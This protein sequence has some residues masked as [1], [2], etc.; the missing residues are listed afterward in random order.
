MHTYL[1]CYPCFLRQALA[2]LRLITDQETEQ[3][4]V[5]DQVMQAL[6]TL[7]LAYSPPRIA[8]TVYE[9]VARE[10]GIEDP[11]QEIKTASNRQALAA[12]P[13]LV[14]IIAQKPNRLRAAASLAISGN[15]IDFGV[16]HEG[17]KVSEG[18]NSQIPD[19][20]DLDDF[21]AFEQQLPGTTK[22]LYI[23][24]N[25]GEIVADKIFISQ[26][27]AAYP[28]LKVGFAV[29]GT[30]IINDVTIVDAEQVGMAEVAGII[31]SGCRAPAL[32]EDEMSPEMADWFYHATMIIAKG[33]GNYEALSQSKQAIFFLLQCKCPVVADDLKVEV[34]S[35]I[36]KYH[37]RKQG[38]LK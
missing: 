4:R 23:G 22:L 30:P 5:L 3:K 33:Q 8:K 36:F 37:R 19:H 12:L 18:L 6:P 38:K 2:S 17:F 35:T 16:Q 20:F 24:D 28:Q 11:Y 7:P 21:P 34:G 15:L 31:N 1:D 13:E 10:T 32:L 25:A 9:I 26:M 14:R 27:K 29:R